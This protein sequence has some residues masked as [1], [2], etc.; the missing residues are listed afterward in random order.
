MLKNK[1]GYIPLAFVITLSFVG[2]TCLKGFSDTVKDGT[3]KRNGKVIW[4][5]MQNKGADYCDEKYK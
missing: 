2:A 4:C 5:K 3:A 1:K